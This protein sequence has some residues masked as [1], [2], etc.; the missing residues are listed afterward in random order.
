[1]CAGTA[2]ISVPPPTSAETL[3]LKPVS[4]ACVLK[5]SQYVGQATACWLLFVKVGSITVNLSLLTS[6]KRGLAMGQPAGV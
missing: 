4:G 6:H 3:I 2:H 5:N 1:M